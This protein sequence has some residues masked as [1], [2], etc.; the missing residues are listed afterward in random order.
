MPDPRPPRSRDPKGLIFEAF[1]I[2]GITDAE[3]RSIFVDWALS[4]QADD[5]RPLIEAA[6]RQARAM[7]P[8][9]TR[10]AP[11]WPRG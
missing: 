2:D 6:A 8:R 7:S 9:I 3:C 4:V 10:C 5:P 11:S 1:R